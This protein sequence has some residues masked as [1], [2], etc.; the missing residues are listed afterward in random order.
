MK[1]IFYGRA[2]PEALNLTLSASPRI[3]MN[4]PDINQ[5]ISMIISINKSN[6]VV[7]CTMDSFDINNIDYYYIRVMDFTRATVDAF[8]FSSG[9]PFTVVIERYAVEGE[10]VKTLS[11]QDPSL[12]SVVKSF[13]AV[14]M[15]EMVS[16]ILS[17]PAIFMALNDLIVSITLPHHAAINCA[18]AIEGIRHLIAGVGMEP[19][20]AWPMMREALNVDAA[21]LSLITKTSKDPRHGNRSHISGDVIGEVLMRSWKIMDRFLEYRKRGKRRLPLDEYPLLTG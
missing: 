9:I 13:R 21:F 10:D 15:G 18:R 20:K 5:N 4:I 8:S 16:I 14:D 2:Y 7:N 17:D 12:S 11:P 19:K 6:I 3:E 1:V